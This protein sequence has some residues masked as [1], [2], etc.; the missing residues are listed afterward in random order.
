MIY[1]GIALIVIGGIL[2]FVRASTQKK[3]FEIKSTE[4]FKAKDLVDLYESVKSDVGMGGFSKIIEV[5][6]MS[7]ADN[8]LTSEIAKQP[9][10]YY[11]MT[12]TREY[13]E[14]Y[15]EKDANG[16]YVTKTRRAEDTI[17]S[18]TQRIPFYVEDETGKVLVNPNGASID[19]QQVVDKFEPGERQAGSMLSFGAF[20][21]NISTPSVG[22]TRTLGYRFRESIIPLDR[23]LYVLGE[24][25]DTSGELAI[26]S[27]REKGKK[28]IVSM[29]SEEELV[30][31]AESTIKWTLYAAIA[32]DVI[33][34]ILLVIGL[35]G[36]K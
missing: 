15:Q 12:V 33:G 28:F 8:P 20:S 25:T 3:L 17:S 13:E 1:I 32:C 30:R 34:L 4:T 27:P 10:V 29:K 5:K 16:N 14:T 7:K 22:R 36:K 21:I 6:G 31:G 18:N 2:I 35:V 23:K 19:A 26:Q 11:S 9:C 24:A